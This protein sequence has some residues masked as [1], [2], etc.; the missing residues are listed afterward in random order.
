[1]LSMNVLG[2]QLE[3]RS[4]VGVIKLHKK[5][6]GNM[7]K[8]ERLLALEAESG[9]TAAEIAKLQDFKTEDS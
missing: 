5:Y 8:K 1:M 3:Q 6:F 2:S 9:G 4:A 7:E